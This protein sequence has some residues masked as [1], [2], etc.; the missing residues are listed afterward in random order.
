MTQI[1]LEAGD[2]PIRIS[3]LGIFYTDYIQFTPDAT[4][5]VDAPTDG[6][7]LVATTKVKVSPYSELDTGAS[8]CTIN[9]NTVN[10]YSNAD[11]L[12]CSM[13]FDQSSEEAIVAVT[14]PES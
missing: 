7:A 11:G 6:T 12:T 13:T 3:H 1:L 14:V 2:C 8:Y 5:S 9:D 4:G 10:D